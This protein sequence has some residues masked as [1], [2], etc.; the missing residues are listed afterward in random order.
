[1]LRLQRANQLSA[2]RPSRHEPDARRARLRQ[3]DV[4]IH[5]RV[6]LGQRHLAAAIRS[7]GDEDGGARRH[8]VFAR[9]GLAHRS[10]RVTFTPSAFASTRSVLTGGSSVAARSPTPPS[11]YSPDPLLAPRTVTSQLLD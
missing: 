10:S 1:R 4:A 5:H 9:R 6:H 11:R 2:T 8:H 3:R 7:A